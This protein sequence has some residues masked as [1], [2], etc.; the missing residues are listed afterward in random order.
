M[1]ALTR[2]RWRS[3]APLGAMHT[4]A[5]NMSS[6][7]VVFFLACCA[8]APPPASDF[9][10]D[11]LGL[12]RAVTRSSGART[13]YV[14]SDAHWV[15]LE[16]KFEDSLVAPTYRKVEASRM[17]LP[18]TYPLGQGKPYRIEVSNFAGYEGARLPISR[19][20][21]AVHVAGEAWSRAG[22]EWPP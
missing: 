7:C 21:R 14:G 4:H 1:Q 17:H 22:I 2:V 18:R 15:Y 3:S 19:G 12:F 20:A 11:W 8:A 13:Y 6:L 9:R 10:D 5:S 16:T